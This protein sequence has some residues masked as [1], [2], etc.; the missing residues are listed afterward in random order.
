MAGRSMPLS[1]PS[2]KMAE[3][4]VQ[5]PQIAN[6][7]KPPSVAFVAVKNNT[8]EYID[9]SAFLRK[10]RTHIM[11]HAGGKIGFLDREIKES[12][13]EE[14]GLKREGVVGASGQ[15]ILLG[16]DYFLTG[17]ISS[18]DTRGRGRQST[19]MLYSFRLTDSESGLVIWED[20]YEV[21]KAALKPIWDR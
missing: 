10:I 8:N 7:T 16:A 3:A 5:L 6:A 11:S 2:R 19:Y 14:R 15:K 1:R 4:I 18:I 13:L 12:I 9:T 21:K 17:A 20:D